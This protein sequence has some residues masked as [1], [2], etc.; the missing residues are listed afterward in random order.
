[1]NTENKTVCPHCG[2]TD[3]V[4]GKQAGHADV[5]TE[6]FSFRHQTLYH[7]ICKKCGTVARSYVKNP[8]MLCGK[9]D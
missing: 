8:E 2:G 6:N 4:I 5:L 9:K 7:E 3:F 1:M